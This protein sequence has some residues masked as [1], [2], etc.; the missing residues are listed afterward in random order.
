MPFQS[1]KIL[2]VFTVGALCY[3][4]MEILCRGFTHITMGLLGGSAF[5]VIHTLNSDRRDGKIR[6]LPILFISAF[7]ITSIEF[8]SGEI[9]NRTLGMNIWSYSEIPFNLDG[10]ICVPFA[11]IW[12]GVSLIG[13]AADDYLRKFIFHEKIICRRVPE[14]EPQ[15]A[16]A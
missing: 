3:G 11:V 8:L 2:T 9:L 12:F 6:L 7:F 13:V 10:Q 16:I 4:L 15:G 1:T 5:L 14:A